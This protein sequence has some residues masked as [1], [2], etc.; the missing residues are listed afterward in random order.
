[1]FLACSDSGGNFKTRFCKNFGIFYDIENFEFFAVLSPNTPLKCPKMVG[2]ER[3]RSGK[4]KN[5]LRIDL[6]YFGGGDILFFL[7][8]SKT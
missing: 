2:V 8:F 3:S 5:G 4:L 7:S 6:K 1:M